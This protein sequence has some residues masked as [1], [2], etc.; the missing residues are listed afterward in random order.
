MTIEFAFKCRTCGAL[1]PPGAAGEN[2][3]PAKCHVCDA[4]AHFDP[5][6]GK[7]TLEPDNWIT[8][9]DLD[10]DER[11]KELA[12]YALDPEQHSIVAHAPEMPTAHRKPMAV[13]VAGMETLDAVE[14]A[15]VGRE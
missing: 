8:L 3:T 4:G 7:R 1:E 10:D 9:A 15:T 5:K 2:E 14:L 6:S 13:S 11:G 12:P